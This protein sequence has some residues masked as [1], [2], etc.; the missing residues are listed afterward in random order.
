MTTHQ[1]RTRARGF[2][3]KNRGVRWTAETQVKTIA[4]LVGSREVVFSK[5]RQLAQ[6]MPESSI[7]LSLFP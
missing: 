2:D 5:H 1:S 4:D 3:P 6:R 7:Y